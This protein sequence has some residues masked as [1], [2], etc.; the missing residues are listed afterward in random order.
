MDSPQP[1]GL[2]HGL[3]YAGVGDSADPGRTPDIVGLTGKVTFVGTVTRTIITG[4][5]DP[6]IIVPQ[7]IVATL[8]DGI[9]YW[10]GVEDI[11]LTATLDEAGNSLGWQ[12][13]ITFQNLTLPDTTLAFLTG[14]NLDVKVYDPNAALDEYGNNPT[15]TDIT[16]QAPAIAPS[17][18]TI[19]TKGPK[20]DTGPQ[21]PKGDTG[22]AVS[23]DIADAAAASANASAASAT[24]SATSATNSA[25]SA[26]SSASSATDAAN[27]AAAVPRWWTGT[28][29]AYNALVTKDPSTLYLITG[30]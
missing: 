28:Q 3:I 13:K 2:V 7:S 22:D 30:P 11:P 16:E 4:V 14:W 19:I 8:T 25:A 1:F 6:M 27:T 20:G 17:G 26:T 10:A 15:I 18:N 12:W 5:A 23:Q 24:N 29:T 9:L 21:G